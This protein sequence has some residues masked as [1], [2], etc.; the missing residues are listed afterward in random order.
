MQLKYKIVTLSVL[1]LIVSVLFICVLV[2]AQSQKLEEE[3][4]KLVES[5]IM[6]AKKAELKN[7]LEL[8]LSLIAPLYESGRDDEEA[9]Q[10]AL[11]MLARA[12]FGL[13]G[14]FFVYDRHGKNLMHPRQA[15]LVGKEL[16]GMKDKNGLPVIQALLD[17]AERGDG[18]Q[19]YAWEKPSTRQVTEKL[20]Y[21]VMLDRWGW[22]LG[23]G[24]YIDDVEVA[25]L[26]SRQEVATGVLTTVL[27]IASFSLIA[28]LV[29]F[30]GGLMLNFTEHRLADRK[31]SALNQRIVHLQEEER[32]RVSRELHDGISQQLVSIKFQ[33]ELAGLELENGRERGLENLRAG[34]ARLG[35]AIGEIRRISHD[36]RP[37]LLD[38]LGLSPAI[39]QLIHEFEQRTGIRTQYERGLDDASLGMDVRV[40][41]FRII[42]EALGNIERHSRASAAI[43]SLAASQ[44]AIVLRV[45]DNGVGFD[46]GLVDRSH[47]IGLRNIRERVDHHRGT[48]TISS[49]HGRT[50]LQ[51]EIPVQRA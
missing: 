20:S 48:F 47:G 24:I 34:T 31:L 43:I 46:T 9:R 23:T 49:S 27:A 18:Y 36:L 15:N 25:T 21:V 5:S 17:S 1:P 13:D 28:I 45:E 30:T 7:Y 10:Q 38:T 22:M 51:V 39:D 4:A 19:L 2:F 44:G 14:Y 3:Q 37:S 11:R 32:S 16:I 40:T 33:F 42:Q 26:K 41:L 6:A 35:E 29:V 12:S 8:A 50:E